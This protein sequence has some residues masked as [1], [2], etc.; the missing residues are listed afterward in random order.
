VLSPAPTAFL[1]FG[2][3]RVTTLHDIFDVRV[4]PMMIFFTFAFIG[5]TWLNQDFFAHR[6]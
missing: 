1:F 6:L 4:S 5:R 2:A 3:F